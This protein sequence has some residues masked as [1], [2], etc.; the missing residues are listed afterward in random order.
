MSIRRGL[1]A[2]TAGVVGSFYLVREKD[3]SPLCSPSESFGTK[4]YKFIRPILFLIDPEKAHFLTLRTF[5]TLAQIIP[6]S[7]GNFSPY[8]HQQLFGISFPSPVGLAAGFDKNAELLE[9]YSK[10]W[11][12][13]GSSEIGSVSFKSWAGN[14]KPRNFRV[15]KSEAVIN[16]MGLNNDGAVQV[17]ERLKQSAKCRNISPVGVNIVKTADTS[18]V[19]DEA[20]TDFLNSFEI[21]SNHASWIT[22]NVSCP[23]TAEGKTFE[24]PEAFQNLISEIMKRKAELGVQTPV[25]VKLSPLPS[26][27]ASSDDIIELCQI[28][29]S[30][31]VDGLVLANTASDRSDDLNLGSEVVSIGKGGVSGRPLFQR[32]KRLVKEVYQATKGEVPIIAVGGV[33]SAEDAYELIKNGASLVQLYSALVYQGPFIFHD[34]NR[35]IERLLRM[36]GYSNIAE[37]RG[38]A[39]S[40]N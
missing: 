10:N 3:Y 8:L 22:L 12:G 2:T 16:R 38:Q 1:L 13:N 18:I 7:T 31:G 39:V 25:L 33:S 27:E 9:F 35:G 40:Q 30:L 6:E 34:I 23:N 15:T 4:I 21:L 20:I 36:D 37:A 11:L 32:T 26:I 29:I 28:A 17:S 14:P 19:D 5:S 24:C